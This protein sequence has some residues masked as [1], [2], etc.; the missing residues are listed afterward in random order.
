MERDT[1]AEGEEAIREAILAG[2]EKLPRGNKKLEEDGKSW[3]AILTYYSTVFPEE[4][5]SKMRRELAS[6]FLKQALE[7]KYGKDGWTTRKIAV[8]DGSKKTPW[9][10]IRGSEGEKKYLQTD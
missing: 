4:I 8:K 7:R 9:I 2:F 10:F 1:R 3:S 6:I 5:P